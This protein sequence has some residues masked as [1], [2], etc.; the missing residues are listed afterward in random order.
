LNSTP[1]NS[2]QGIHWPSVCQFGL[3]ALA[4]FILWSL[5]FLLFGIGLAGHLLGAPS[6]VD[7]LPAFM[8]S[9]SLILSGFLVTPSAFLAL[10]HLLGKSDSGRFDNFSKKISR[11]TIRSIAAFWVLSFPLIILM[12]YWVS[13]KTSFALFFLPLIHIL[14]I[15]L[16]IIGLLYIALRNLPTGTGQHSW[17]VF[18]TG[19]VL[20]PALILILESFM[21]LVFIVMGALAIARQ[22][23]LLEEITRLMEWLRQT[24][25]SPQLMLDKFSPYLTNP[26]LI[27]MVIMFGAV[28]V[29]L[30]EEALKPIA[31]WFFIGSNISPLTGFVY[32]AI[33]GAGYALFESLALTARGQEWAG[34]VVGRVGTAA[35]HILTTG[36]TGW[37]LASAWKTNRYQTLGGAYLVAVLIHSLWNGL[38]LVTAFS[39]LNEIIEAQ[40]QIPIISQLGI[41][42]P[43][44]L[45]T[46]AIGSL[47]VIYLANKSFPKNNDPG[48][49]P[50]VNSA[51]EID[52]Q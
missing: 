10:Q 5:G 47:V 42:A 11:F 17:G 35:I 52:R 12:G 26:G 34:L 36:L 51:Q 23:G 32:G 30:I 46:L 29:P 22:P 15:S 49:I 27:L 39:V 13:Q 8:M 25:P 20:S 24:N 31:V 40:V 16:P 44:G 45:V 33:C 19:L 43:F 37:A 1:N 41:V 28:V 38:T 48:E 2:A 14:A 3:S 6:F 21:V 18:A 7:P 9:F 4:I 50:L